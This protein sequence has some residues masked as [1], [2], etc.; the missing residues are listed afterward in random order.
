[1]SYQGTYAVKT[2]LN[3]QDLMG[4]EKTYGYYDSDPKSN[5]STVSSC[6]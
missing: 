1:M 6:S 4:F 5:A 2:Q 3:K